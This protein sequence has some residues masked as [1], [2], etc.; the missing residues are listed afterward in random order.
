MSN[1]TIADLLEKD[2]VFI[3]SDWKEDPTATDSVLPGL[4]YVG[5]KPCVMCNDVFSWGC[6][7]SEGIT[8]ETLPAFNQARDECNGDLEVAAMLYCARQGKIRPQGA[9]YTYIP[10]HLWPLFD[11]CGPKRE[12]D[13][14]NPYKPGEYKKKQA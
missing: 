7:D 14:G 12:I 3:G 8:E 6:A 9:M 10:K 5:E 11:A 4:R 13:A 1:Y 2:I